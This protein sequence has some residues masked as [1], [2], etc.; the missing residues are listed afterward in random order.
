MFEVSDDI[1][2]PVDRCLAIKN[3]T[4]YEIY[5]KSNLTNAMWNNNMYS[6]SWRLKELKS[7]HLGPWTVISYRYSLDAANS[8]QNNSFEVH[9]EEVSQENFNLNWFS[10]FNIK[11]VILQLV[12]SWPAETVIIGKSSSYTTF[13]LAKTF[14]KQT[15]CEL[16]RN[17]VKSNSFLNITQKISTYINHQ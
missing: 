11:N 6:C 9:G 17:A 3:G 2:T 15:S 5:P 12:S 7:E 16:I 8:V 10:L 14:E 13:Y 4:T 1:G